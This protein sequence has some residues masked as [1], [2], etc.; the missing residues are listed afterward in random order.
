MPALRVLLPTDSYICISDRR[1][2]TLLPC[3][4]MRPIGYS[5]PLGLGS[6]CSA[7][8]PRGPPIFAHVTREQGRTLS[9]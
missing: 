2:C 8:A 5:T 7:S 1:R 6:R 3:V 9:S 4:L